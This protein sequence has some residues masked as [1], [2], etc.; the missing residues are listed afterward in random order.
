MVSLF[1][2]VLELKDSR[3]LITEPL[4]NSFVTKVSLEKQLQ[5]CCEYL[6]QIYFDAFYNAIQLE[7]MDVRSTFVFHEKDAADMRPLGC[8]RGAI[9]RRNWRVRDHMDAIENT[10]IDGV[11]G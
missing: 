5:R 8:R 10:M 3:R 4:L 11:E 6:L 7:R 2:A 9:H 1:P